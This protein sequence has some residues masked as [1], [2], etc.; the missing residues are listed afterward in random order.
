LLDSIMILP[1]LFLFHLTV[2]SS[3]D[4]CI[5]AGPALSGGKDIKSD[6]G[7]R[8]PPSFPSLNRAASWVSLKRSRTVHHASAFNDANFSA[9]VS[10]SGQCA[11]VGGF[12]T[13]TPLT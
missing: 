6:R 12:P 9:L 4:N 8:C 7:C 11:S 2:L 1:G 10:P 5:A 13:L 3:T